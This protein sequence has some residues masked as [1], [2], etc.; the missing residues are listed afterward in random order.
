M[1]L[2]DA[3]EKVEKCPLATDGEGDAELP[4]P[5]ASGMGGTG[6]VAGEK[7]RERRARRASLA[8]LA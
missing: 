3:F 1:G 4:A 8:V 5:G 6:G 7:L 2:A